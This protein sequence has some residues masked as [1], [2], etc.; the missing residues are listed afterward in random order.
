MTSQLCP[1]SAEAEPGLVRLPYGLEVARK[2]RKET[3]FHCGS[4]KRKFNAICSLHSHLKGDSYHYDHVTMTAYP[5]N[6][7]SCSKKP[8]V[9]DG[10]ETDS[11]F[12]DEEN[13]PTY[14]TQSGAIIG[15]MTRYRRKHHGYKTI[16]KLSDFNEE[17]SHKVDIK[18]EVN[19][20]YTAMEADPANV[21]FEYTDSKPDD[22][23]SAAKTIVFEKDI[24]GSLPTDMLTPDK[25]GKI[26]EEIASVSE[27]GTQTKDS[28][29][30]EE[31]DY[32]TV[33][34]ISAEMGTEMAV[35]PDEESM[36]QSAVENEV[37]EWTNEG[38]T[39]GQVNMQ[40]TINLHSL[41]TNPDGSL[42]IVVGEEDAAIFKTPQGEEILKALKEQA[43]KGVVAK[44][45][46]VVY[47]YT[48]PA[49]SLRSG[50]QAV[51]RLK[52][53]SSDIDD[54]GSKIKKKK[55]KY[56]PKTEDDEI[57]PDCEMGQGT[58]GLQAVVF[59][60]KEDRISTDEA[61]H[62]LN[63][64]EMGMHEDKISKIQPI[65]AKGGELYVI[66]LEALPD[67]RDC[68]HDKYLWLHCGKKSYPKQK[69]KISK[70]MYKVKL[71]NQSYSD[72]FQKNVFEPIDPSKRYAL[73]HYTGYESLFQPL[74]HGNR[75]YGFKAHQR[76][77]PSVLEELRAL[78]DK[79]DMSPTMIHKQI[80][81]FAPEP[82][83]RNLRT[84][85]D[86]RQI[87]NFVVKAKRKA[88]EQSHTS[89]KD[90]GMS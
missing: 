48:V 49:D 70:A 13:I 36:E 75:K 44:N 83:L 68:R 25:T 71:P 59:K 64:C 89:D 87:R 46:Q 69:P 7:K 11:D 12:E 57:D 76:T 34:D 39:P 67:R 81:S 28:P 26:K 61:M 84:P 19:P 86:L 88:R 22:T 47:N 78:S 79:T 20:E 21:T 54:D 14:Y 77:C 41:E 8:V 50:Q 9:A 56:K 1:H 55:K 10:H 43:A 85:R 38:E 32:K 90:G 52:E 17:V 80:Q 74:P 51:S 3:Y 53:E 37:E 66:D 65:N 60:M 15:K 2:K 35:S 82:G 45:T 30:I 73:V 18:I 62:I 58:E 29:A 33:R 63:E 4:C 31:E 24:F 23:D 42:K 5:L 16:S 40:M 27:S 72:G 6:P